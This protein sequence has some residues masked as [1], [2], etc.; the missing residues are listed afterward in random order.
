MRLG[1]ILQLLA[2]ICCLLAAPSHAMHPAHPEGYSPEKMYQL[3]L[4]D[5]VDLFGGSLSI[6]IP[7]GPLTLTYGSTIWTYEYE[8]D[9]QANDLRIVVKPNKK[10]TGGLGW[11][12]GW[13]EVYRPGHWYN[14]G[15]QWV[16]VDQN[17]GRHVFYQ[18]LHKDEDDG[19]ADVLY[20]RD[21]SYLRLRR[22]PIN[23]SSTIYKVWIEHPDG[24]TRSFVAPTGQGGT[25][26]NL[27]AGWSA[28]AAEGDPDFSVSYVRGTGADGLE[29]WILTDRWGRVTRVHST[30]EYTNL[31]NTVTSVELPPAIQGGPAIV[32]GF[33]YVQASHKR[34]CKDTHSS[35]AA[36]V[37]VPYL[38]RIDLPDGTS[39][40]MKEGGALLYETQCTPTDDA[41]GVLKGLILPSGAKVE[42]EWQQVKF[43]AVAGEEIQHNAAGVKFRRLYDKNGQLAGE[44]RYKFNQVMNAGGT[45]Q[46]EMRSHLVQPTGDCTKSY[47]DARFK[48]SPALKLGWRYGLPGASS[49]TLDVNGEERYM[50]KK[51]FASNN[52]DGSC[53]GTL[54]RSTYVDHRRD[55]PPTNA[56]NPGDWRNLNRGLYA[57]HTIY[58]DDGDRWTD[59]KSTSFDGLGHFRRTKTWGNFWGGSSNEEYRQTFTDY[60]DAIGF[61][62]SSGYVPPAATDPWVLG[63]WSYLEVKEPDSQGEWRSRI[64]QEVDSA[65]GAV[66]CS[67]VLKSDLSRSA[68]DILAR[69]DRDSLGQVTDAK[70]YG[71]DLQPIP[72][73]GT[74]GFVVAG[75]EYWTHHEYERG[76]R[77]RTVQR[78]SAGVDAP[79]FSYDVDL[80]PETGKVL[81]ARDPA[82]QATTYSYDTLGRL[83]GAAP[84]EGAQVSYVYSSPSASSDARVAT[85]VRLGLSVLSDSEKVYDEFGRLSLTRRKMPGGSWSSQETQYNARGW[86]TSVSVLGDDPR[87]RTRYLAFDAFGRPGVIRPP[88]GASHDL[89]ITYEGIRRTT[90]QVKVATAAGEVYQPVIQESDRYGRLRTLLEASGAGGVSIPTS[91]FYDVGSRMTSL[92]TPSAPA[93]GPPQGTVVV[94][95]RLFNYDNR[96][97]LLSETHPEK[98]LSGN[99]AV[100]YEDYDSSGLAHRVID[101]PDDLTKE[102]DF[103]GRL[104]AVRDQSHGG[105]LLLEAEFDGASGAGLGRPWKST[106]HN[107][108][109]LPWDGPGEVD[110]WVR[111]TLSFEGPNGALSMTEM[112]VAL[113]GVKSFETLYDYNE[114]GLVSSLRYP[115]CVAGTCAGAGAPARTIAAT[116]DQGLLKE[117]PGWTGGPMTYHPSGLWATIPHANGV[118]DELVAD[119]VRPGRPLQL[120]VLATDGT[121]LWNKGAYSYDGAG[122]VEAIGTSSFAYDEV[123]RLVEAAVEGYEQRFTYDTF[124]NL[125]SFLTKPPQGPT[126]QLQIPVDQASNRL[127]SASYDSAGNTT[128]WSANHYEWDAL[129]RMTSLNDR[130]FYLYD[131]GGERAVAI[132]WTGTLDARTMTFTL[133]GLAG[134]VLSQFEVAGDDSSANWQH[135]RDWILAGGRLLATADAEGTVAH[136]HLDH[137]GSVRLRTDENGFEL[138]RHDYLPYGEEITLPADGLLKFTGHERDG[139]AGHDF[140]HARYYTW[141]L[142]RFLSV[143]PGRGQAG[144]PHTLNLYSYSKGNPL[145]FVDPDGR[146]FRTFLIEVG[147]LGGSFYLGGK[148]LL[149]EQAGMAAAGVAGG[150]AAAFVGAGISGYA[151]GTEINGAMT[152]FTSQP[153]WALRTSGLLNPGLAW[154]YRALTVAENPLEWQA[155]HVQVDDKGRLVFIDGANPQTECPAGRFCADIE[156][157]A[158]GA[159]KS[160]SEE[161]AEKHEATKHPD[162]LLLP[163]EPIGG[164]EVSEFWI[165]LLNFL[166]VSGSRS[167]AS[168]YLHGGLLRIQ[169]DGGWGDFTCA[170]DITCDPYAK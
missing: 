134:E 56:D 73:S 170:T 102:Y 53:A 57:S 5:Q 4:P 77:V 129:G 142:G 39:W 121:E 55:V 65:T 31:I 81:V 133:R 147:A 128:N 97:F 72:T 112:K 119:P 52:G 38:E 10:N 17:G 11:T 156:V 120:K 41:A 96:G 80:D 25:A 130:F 103:L 42:W 63:K 139:D 24:S 154:L 100:L 123:S 66:T 51:I 94:Q 90:R 137:L 28:F 3:G 131:S 166:D 161:I 45:D 68:Q 84:A 43:P 95:D 6:R 146:S 34:S 148:V 2:M 126:H 29:E 152:A 163:T 140:M 150:G 101:G 118:T 125:T 78:T 155:G 164:Q 47:Y 62:P 165:E 40:K 113:E 111:Q 23:G 157:T 88:Q 33:S 32:Y 91:Y 89:L 49:D 169:M 35:T 167:F 76:A 69:F 74:C 104:T 92:S 149:A 58:H 93:I 83:I 122:N 71:G 61:Y 7:I 27:T 15:T 26:F 162:S 86:K 60:T 54:L 64:E 82:G 8:W 106:R 110:A 124:A 151:I 107:W 145:Q 132:D 153:D 116:Y 19:D 141:D 117:I 9:E 21:S 114:Q 13:G 50:A 36:T 160:L 127:T 109:D 79:F 85:K 20:T 136:L 143:D 158:E 168:T 14:P 99:G 144:S 75:P 59:Q 46:H 98:G 1:T 30:N 37:Q 44:W 135:R 22:F 12:L 159:E 70:I 138:S 48:I 87:K 18:Q 108:L 16:Y 115:E 105:R 67:R